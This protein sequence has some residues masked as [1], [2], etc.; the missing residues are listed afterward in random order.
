MTENLRLFLASTF[1]NSRADCVRAQY[2]AKAIVMDLKITQK[3]TNLNRQR[4]IHENHDLFM[5]LLEGSRYLRLCIYVKSMS[6]V[7]HL[8]VQ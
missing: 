1:P 6:S 2:P 4:T 7:I 5:S 8:H 3:P